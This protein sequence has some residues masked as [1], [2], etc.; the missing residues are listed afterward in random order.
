MFSER[1]RGFEAGNTKGQ[2]NHTNSAHYNGC[3]GPR[4]SGKDSSPKECLGKAD[5]RPKLGHVTGVTWVTILGPEMKAHSFR[6]H[7]P[8]SLRSQ[9]G[10]RESGCHFYLF[11][12]LCFFPLFCDNE[13]M[14]KLPSLCLNISSCWQQ[15]DTP[16]STVRLESAIFL[17]SKQHVS[18][19]EIIFCLLV[20]V[21][22][23]VMEPC[24][25]TCQVKNKKQV[26]KYL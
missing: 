12:Y 6:S 2:A 5:K 1:S 4:I 18:W 3:N 11:I 17:E 13:K 24:D 16:W 9:Q 21:T 26:W 8:A 23:G 25:S 20:A 15:R 22:L 10:V 19:L 7:D 14:F